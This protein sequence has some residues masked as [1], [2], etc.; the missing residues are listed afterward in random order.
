MHQ[1]RWETLRGLN[2]SSRQPQ[3]FAKPPPLRPGFKL[4]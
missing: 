2:G 4:L 3:H 1:H